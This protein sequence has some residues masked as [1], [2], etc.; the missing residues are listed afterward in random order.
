MSKSDLKIAPLDSIDLNCAIDVKDV[1]KK[2]P[3]KINKND[4]RVYDNS[5]KKYLPYSEDY[6]IIRSTEFGVYKEHYLK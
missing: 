1:V 4:F 5:S 3:S 2:I 6:D